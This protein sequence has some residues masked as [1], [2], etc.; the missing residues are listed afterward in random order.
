[1]NVFSSFNTLIWATE[2]HR[3]SSCPP[4]DFLQQ[5]NLVIGV[6]FGI[7]LLQERPGVSH[8]PRIHLWDRKCTNVK[9]NPQPKSFS[10]RRF[11]SREVI[12][13]LGADAALQLQLQ[14]DHVHL[15]HVAQ[16]VEL[17]HLARHFING[18][19]NGVHFRAL[20]LHHLDALLQVREAGAR[21]ESGERRASRQKELSTAVIG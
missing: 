6:L 2:N 12:S 3:I 5:L 8:G 17:R 20:L 4:E 10:L 19:L 21:C 14:S 7:L 11:S 16:L 18:H 1:M 9:Q 15:L 13:H